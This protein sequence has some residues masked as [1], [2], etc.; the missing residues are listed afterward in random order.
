DLTVYGDGSQTRS[1][2]YVSDE[3]DGIL[4]LAWSTEQEPTNVGN[5]GEFTILECAREVLRITNSES[6]IKH[7]PLPQ[8]DPKQRRPDITKARKLLGWEPRIDLPTGL[9][10]SLDYFRAEV[11]AERTVIMQSARNDLNSLAARV[12]KDAP[13]EEAAVLAWPLACGSAVA[14]RTQALLYQNGTLW[15][16]VP[17][18]SWQSQ[19]ED[20]NPQY[21]ARILLLTGITVERIRYDVER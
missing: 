2:C 21:K 19:L 13:A 4:K 1:F 12:L 10:L 6:G 9:R 14:G 5:P 8:D 18:R 15:V 17:D 3:I 20:F 16:R 11:E 7:L